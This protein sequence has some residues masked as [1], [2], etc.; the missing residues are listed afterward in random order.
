MNGS[1]GLT[2]IHVCG[3]E[4]M[5]LGAP[6]SRRYSYIHENTTNISGGKKLLLTN[7]GR[8]DHGGITI[9]FLMEYMSLC[10]Q[11][12]LQVMLPSAC[13][14]I[15]LVFTVFHY[16]LRPTWPYSCVG[17]IYFHMPEGFC[18]AAFFFFHVF[19]LC[20]FSFVFFL[21]CFSFVNFVVSCVYVCLLAR[22]R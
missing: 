3:E 17:Y 7:F 18:F 4:K 22:R 2:I 16:T 14:F 10:N 21:C 9:G 11:W 8:P 19:T 20:T 15:V 13:S 12:V 1:G 6:S 5:L